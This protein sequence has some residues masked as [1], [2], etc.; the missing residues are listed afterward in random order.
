MTESARRLIGWQRDKL[1]DRQQ[2]ESE[3]TRCFTAEADKGYVQ[4]ADLQA[5]VG[6]KLTADASGRLTAP[7]L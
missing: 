6:V 7:D 3:Q 5:Q 1:A 4:P 2:I